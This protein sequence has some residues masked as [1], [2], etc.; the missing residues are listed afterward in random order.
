M[1]KTLSETFRYNTLNASKQLL[2][3]IDIAK[4]EKWTMEE[5]ASNVMWVA[6]EMQKEYSENIN[7]IIKIERDIDF[8]MNLLRS[9]MDKYIEKCDEGDLSDIKDVL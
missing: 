7:D 9:V 4:E 2:T 5:L 1:K 8:S 3:F 6:N